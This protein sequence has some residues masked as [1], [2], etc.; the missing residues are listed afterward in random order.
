MESDVA[1]LA[2]VFKMMAF[3]VILS[4]MINFVPAKLLFLCKNNYN[5]TKNLRDTEMESAHEKALL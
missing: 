5:D 3:L 2:N 4:V 1:S